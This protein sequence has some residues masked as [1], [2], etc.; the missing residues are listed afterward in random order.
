MTRLWPVPCV[1]LAVVAGVASSLRAGAVAQRWVWTEI[2]DSLLSLCW[3]GGFVYSLLIV[4]EGGGG[5]GRN[6]KGDGGKAAG[7]R[8]RRGG[9]AQLRHWEPRLSVHEQQQHQQLHQ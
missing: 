9:G 8:L 5:E 4:H 2:N 7:C 6:R 1:E 3:W